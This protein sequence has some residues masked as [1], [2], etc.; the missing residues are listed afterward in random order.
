LGGRE[1]SRIPGHDHFDRTAGFLDRGDR[2]L[3]HAVDLEGNLGRQRAL[4][5]QAHA[6]LA[7]ASHAGRLERVVVHHRL[8]VELA[9][10]DQLLDLAEIH[11]G[12]VLAERVVEAALRQAHVER[13]LAALEALDGHARAALLALL[14]A[15][16]GLAL[17]G[18][19]AASDAHT[20]L[21]GARIVTDVVEFHFVAL[22]FA[23]FAPSCGPELV[24]TQAISRPP[25]PCAAAWRSRRGPPECPRARPHDAFFPGRDR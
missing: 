24:G 18:A 8:G 1:R 16:A 5:E 19:D 23:M 20:A 17:A 14:A 3:G 21:A 7:A 25:Q 22:A 4:A 6:L 10:V 12:I 13:H 2:S 15:S 9:G 11:L